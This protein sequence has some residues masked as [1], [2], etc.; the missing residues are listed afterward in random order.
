MSHVL[1][2]RYVSSADNHELIIVMVF[3]GLVSM[4][5]LVQRP[6]SHIFLTI[7]F[8]SFISIVLSDLHLLIFPS[9]LCSIDVY[10][11]SYMDCKYFWQTINYLFMVCLPY[12]S[13][14]LNFFVVK[15]QILP[16]LFLNSMTF[17]PIWHTNYIYI[18][19]GI[20]I[21]QFIFQ[22]TWNFLVYVMRGRDLTK[23]FW[24]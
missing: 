4:L 5:S 19:P 22:F 15:Y 11:L 12:G 18:W 21:T 24:L 10:P 7:S 20:L 23:F 13:N 14:F 2:F 6:C 17:L 8:G 3:P 9:S 1:W 16:L